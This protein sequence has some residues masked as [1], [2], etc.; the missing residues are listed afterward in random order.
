[1]VHIL[2][3]NNGEFWWMSV[4]KKGSSFEE[5]AR[6]TESFTSKQN[7]KKSIVNEAK[8]FAD[9]PIVTIADHTSKGKVSVVQLR[10]DWVFSVVNDGAFYYKKEIEFVANKS[11]N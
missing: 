7:C 1:M 8:I 5:N 10:P 9:T 11:K 2:K 3:N 4:V 6:S